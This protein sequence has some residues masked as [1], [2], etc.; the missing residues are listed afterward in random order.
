MPVR[1]RIL[2]APEELRA[3]WAAVASSGMAEGPSEERAFEITSDLDELR[4]G[5]QPAAEIEL[6]FPGVSSFHA[7]LFRGELPGDWWVEDLGS[8]NGSWLDGT[9]L[10]ARRPARLRS[11]QRV[12]IA[13]VDIVFDG[14]SA[15]HRGS[16]GTATLARRLISDLF[17]V[18]GGDV[19]TLTIES[20]SGHPS[21][22]RLAARDRR[23]LVGR[24]D[25]CD[26]ILFGEHVSREHAAFLRRWDGVVVSDLGSRNGVLVNGQAIPGD[27]KLADGDRIEVG[28]VVLR[29]ADPEDRYLRRMESLEA[30]RTDGAGVG[31]GAGSD[32]GAGTGSPSASQDAS[33][34][35]GGRDGVPAPQ[36][37]PALESQVATA[38]P[39][40]IDATLNPAG[41]DL[42]PRTRRWPRWARWIVSGIAAA[43]VVAAVAGLVVLLVGTR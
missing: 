28:P 2:P 34:R 4:I 32:A 37:T 5:R 36:S 19:P 11:G 39:G 15:T 17:G 21:A 7:R 43:V 38:D 16:E 9:R 31:Q 10:A 24:A 42:P 22:V 41:S 13:T 33:A 6:P 20:G 40:D 1:F 27:L 26:L 30:D 8:T 14:W 12:R 29:L 23:Y 18:V 3:G 35:A 25:G